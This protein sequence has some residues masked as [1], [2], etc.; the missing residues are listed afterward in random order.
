MFSSHPSSLL[1]RIVVSSYPLNPS[2]LSISPLI[3]D[4][5]SGTLFLPFLCIGLIVLLLLAILCCQR[6]WMICCMGRQKRK[7]NQIADNEKH[8]IE[9][10]PDDEEGGVI[11]ND[12]VEMS[13]EGVIERE[14]RGLLNETEGKGGNVG[15]RMGVE[16]VWAVDD[17]ESGMGHLEEVCKDNRLVEKWSCH[18][19]KSSTASPLPVLSSSNNNVPAKT[20]L[21]LSSPSSSCPA[22]NTPTHDDYGVN[23]DDGVGSEYDGDVKDTRRYVVNVEGVRYSI[24][25]P[26]QPIP[27]LE[28]VSSSSE[29]LD[30]RNAD[31]ESLGNNS[32]GSGV[33]G[34]SDNGT[35]GDDDN[36]SYNS[37]DSDSDCSS[38][39]WENV[40]LGGTVVPAARTAARHITPLSAL[41]R[42][43][44][45][46]GLEA[47]HPV[48]RPL[49]TI[50][51]IITIHPPVITHNTYYLPL[52]TTSTSANI[53]SLDNTSYYSHNNT[54]C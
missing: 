49:V 25:I 42:G 27:A 14:S 9:V 50:H 16:Y 19:K 12:M 37:N 18:V 30:R 10:C 39:S 47:F 6:C 35:F 45:T 54:P 24:R 41:A 36:N 28:D 32:D 20:N 21:W 8:P 40:N 44:Y 5:S 46:V 3:Q 23:A 31:D 26:S 1:R 38:G 52:M 11:Y 22:L 51:P 43:K 2:F 48:T 4:V 29:L 53:P 13:N 15:M 33:S 17:V 34:Y 7:K